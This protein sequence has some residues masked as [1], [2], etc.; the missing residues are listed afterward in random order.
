MDVALPA[1][2][3]SAPVCADRLETGIPTP[4][5]RP[6]AVASN[7]TEGAVKP[8]ARTMNAVAAAKTKDEDV[9]AIAR[10]LPLFLNRAP[11]TLLPNMRAS[12]MGMSAAP[13]EAAAIPI[14]S[15]KSLGRYVTP[16]MS[17]NCTQKPEM[18]PA[19]TLG[20][21]NSPMGI[22]GALAVASIL[23]RTNVR[24]TN[25]TIRATAWGDA[26]GNASPA[27]LNTATRLNTLSDASTLPAH[28]IA[29][30][31]AHRPCPAGSSTIAQTQ[32]SRSECSQR[33]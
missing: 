20:R 9:S 28:R 10:S 24:T 32:Q 31:G 12:V 3:A 30:S 16:A 17:A 25:S 7:V 27:K 29:P 19:T 22:T 26:K 15:C 1:S 2:R 6:S 11:D 5:P 14:D 8:C 23:Y 13:D 18:N 33:I 4:T 21:P